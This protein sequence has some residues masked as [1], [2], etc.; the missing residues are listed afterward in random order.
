MSRGAL[1]CIA[2]ESPNTSTYD[3]KHPAMGKTRRRHLCLD[4]GEKFRTLQEH[5]SD[6][7]LPTGREAEIIDKIDALGALVASLVERAEQR[8]GDSLHG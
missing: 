3:V 5:V 2:C 7:W 4:C 6:S 8:V 1:T